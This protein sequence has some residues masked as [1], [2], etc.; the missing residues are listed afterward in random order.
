MAGNT[1]H[2]FETGL[3]KNRANFAALTPPSFLARAAV[4]FGA[5]VAVI[6]DERRITYAELYDRCR[7]LASAL[8]RRGIGRL[9]TVAI[10]APNI[11]EMIEA[12]FAVPMLGA[13]LNPLNTRLDAATLA[14]SLRHGEAKVL[15][16]DRDFAPLVAQVLALLDEQP[17]LVEVPA[18]AAGPAILEAIGYEDLLHEGDPSYDWPGPD[19]EW[20]SLCLL[21]T[22]GTTG[23][24]KGAVYSHRGAY[25]QALGNAVTFGVNRESVYLWTLPMFHCSGWSYPWAMVAAGGTQ[26]CLRKVEPA[27]IFRLIAEHGVTHLCGAPILLS[28]LVHAPAQDRVPFPQTVRCATGGAAPTST[29]LRAMESM[30]FSVTHLYGATETYGPGTASVAVDAWADL[31]EAERY[32]R[33]ARQGVSLTTVEE[34][35]V[36]DPSALAP[37]PQDGRTIGEI[38]MRGNT[39]MKGYLKNPDATARTLTGGWYLSGDLAVW[40]PDGA[41]EIKDRAKDIIISGGENISSL[42]VEEVLSRHPAVMLAAVVARPDVTWGETPCAFLELKPSGPGATEAEIVAF[43]REHLARFKVPRTIVFGPLPKTATGKIQKF[44]LREQAQAIEPAAKA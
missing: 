8:A 33:M 34:L 6:D 3:D 38:A 42:E 16:V 22:S 27:R 21:Y 2:P 15:I 13:V 19:D 29:I 41:V 12:H 40:H 39:V 5:S 36:V 35:A 31:T 1:G 7:R 30:G 26:V 9:E 10:L 4:S 28:M 37:I 11:P 17:L 32:E 24:P 25:L 23:D 43:C 20:Q 14:F 18:P 44:V